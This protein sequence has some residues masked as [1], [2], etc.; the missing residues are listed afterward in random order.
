MMTSLPDGRGATRYEHEI[1]SAVRLSADRIALVVVYTNG[2]FE[3]SQESA[4]EPNGIPTDVVLLKTNNKL[5]VWSQYSKERSGYT[6]KDGYAYE[7]RHGEWQNTGKVS[8]V[9]TKCPEQVS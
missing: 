3:G 7:L 9:L 2:W 1:R 8:P 4:P 6:W 5:E